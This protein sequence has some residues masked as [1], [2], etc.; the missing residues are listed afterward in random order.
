ML[1]DARI[2]EAILYVE[3]RSYRIADGRIVIGDGKCMVPGASGELGVHQITPIAYRDVTHNKEYRAAILDRG[4]GGSYYTL[5]EPD[6]STLVFK[7]YMHLLQ[8]R[9]GEKWIQHY[10]S[11]DSTY[12]RKVIRAM[13][14]IERNKGEWERKRMATVPQYQPR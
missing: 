7:C 4:K 10:N 14:L 1:Y 2:E 9:W 5:V 11:G 6:Y 12:E 13:Y 8:H 3:S